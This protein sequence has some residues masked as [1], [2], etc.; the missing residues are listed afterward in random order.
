MTIL[1]QAVIPIAL[2]VLLGVLVGRTFSL[3]QTTISQLI[4]YVL[5]P[6]LMIEGLYRTKISLSSA[7]DLI[8]GF[9]L[10]SLVLF[11]FLRIISRLLG[12][13]SE[14]YKSLVICSLLSNN[15]NLGLPLV[16]FVLGEEGLTHSLIYVMASSILMFGVMPPFLAGKSW[17]FG[18]NMTFKSPIIWSM[19]V[20]ILIH[21]SGIQIYPQ[22]QVSIRQLGEACIP[23]ALLLLGIQLSKTNFKVGKYELLTTAIRLLLSPLL[24][25]WIGSILHLSSLD[26]Q[27]LILQSAMPVAVNNVVLATEFGG[28]PSAVSRTVIVSTLSSFLTIPFIVEHFK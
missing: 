6:A 12:L 15:G 7:L 4:L 2:I 3:D 5:F 9:A 20:G 1:L 26:L 22:I 25:W 24:A 27:V 11:I 28:N 13:S 21:I 19:V 8:L 14:V 23:L 18:L 10:V 16:T 17:R